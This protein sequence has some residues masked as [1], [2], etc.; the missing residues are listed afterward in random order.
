MFLTRIIK[1]IRKLKV[2]NKSK[3]NKKKKHNKDLLKWKISLQMNKKL[4][5]KLSR[6]NNKRKELRRKNKK[7]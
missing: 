4:L 5:N 6:R 1:R 3:K 2:I 7:S